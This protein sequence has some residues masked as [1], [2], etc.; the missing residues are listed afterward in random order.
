MLLRLVALLMIA[1]LL[2]AQQVTLPLANFTGT[3]HGVS[4]KKITI[5]NSDG[6]L[7]DFDV[8][9]KTRVLRGKKEISISGLT[10]GDS[11]TIE[12]RQERARFALILTA[13]TITAQ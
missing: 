5:E 1:G 11:V 4:S 10:T 13:V 6:N 12:A 8:N 7:V 2:V 9:R 3:V